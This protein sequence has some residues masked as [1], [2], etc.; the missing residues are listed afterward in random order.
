MEKEYQEGDAAHPETEQGTDGAIEEASAG[1]VERKPS[2]KEVRLPCGVL[3][4]QGNVH[5]EATISKL[6]GRD[7]KEIGARDMLANG[8]KLISRLL[9]NRMDELEGFN[10]QD[11]KQKE[12][13]VKGM[14]SADRSLL[15]LEIHRLSKGEEIKVEVN[16][17]NCDEP[18]EVDYSIDLFPFKAFENWRI[19]P[20]RN[21]FVFDFKDEDLG[22]EATYRFPNGWDEEA[23]IPLLRKNPIEA[24]QLMLSRCLQRYN[25]RSDLPKNFLDDQDVDVIDALIEGFQS[26]LPG[27]DLAPEMSCYNCGSEAT[28]QISIADF[29]FGTSLRKRRK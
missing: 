8:G 17:P 29:F 19:D 16:C 1:A 10:L 22:I 9:H 18:Q 2:K 5:H 15:M 6:T 21:L 28:I 27:H 14:L 23:T 26:N 24:S 7:R 12:A 3:D 25:G 4:A 20:Q 11:P 13:V